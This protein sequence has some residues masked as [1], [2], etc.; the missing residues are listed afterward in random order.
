LFVFTRHQ[1]RGE[2][3]GRWLALYVR[4][5]TTVKLLSQP[6]EGTEMT[7]TSIETFLESI[8]GVDDELASLRGAYMQQCKRP[9]DQ[10]REIMA[11]IKDAGHN[12]KAFR[13]LLR[14]HRDERKHADR[15]AGLEP[16]DADD[17]QRM[18]GDYAETPLGAAAVERQR[19]LDGDEM[20]E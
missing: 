4:R 11:E 15:V 1:A 14:H 12:M 8:D 2:R 17:L 18:L 5:A 13:V 6:K 16:E 7:N 10:L 20:R 3:N 19:K 9:R